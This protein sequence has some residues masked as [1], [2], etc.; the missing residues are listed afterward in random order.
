MAKAIIPSGIDEFRASIL[1]G[2]GLQRANRFEVFIQ[3]E[4]LGF[5]Q[6]PIQTVSLPGRSLDGIPDE[7]TAQ[8]GN[9]RNIPVK[10]GYGGEPSILLG[11]FL[12]QNWDVREYFENWMDLF[13]P[14]D[15]NGFLIYEGSYT[16][17][18]A[19]CDVQILFLDLE[20]N[21]KWGMKLIE[22]YPV[23]IIQEAYSAEMMNQL[24]MLNISI[25]FKEY[26]TQ[27][28]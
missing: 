25:G 23:T 9:P 6:W 10:R 12:D 24:A 22:P 1:G 4:N 19:N 17:L 3:E 20:D 2:N 18:T 15:E 27:Q 7:L 5:L 14:V 21:I 26:T 11:M 16:T 28:L 13:N 8:G